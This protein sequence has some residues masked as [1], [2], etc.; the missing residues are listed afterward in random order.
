MGGSY[1]AFLNYIFSINRALLRSVFY[2][3]KNDGLHRSR[4][5]QKPY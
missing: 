5:I 2:E 3:G 1:G 4:L